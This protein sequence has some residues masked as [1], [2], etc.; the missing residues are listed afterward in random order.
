MKKNDIFTFTAPNG[1]GVTGVI[2]HKRIL[3]KDFVNYIKFEYIAYAQ[4]RLFTCTQMERII[5]K[6]N[7]APCPIEYGKVLIDYCVIPFYDGV[8]EAHEMS[9]SHV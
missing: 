2:I 5:D 3:N 4:N 7:Y 9:N 8:L 1:V 6:E